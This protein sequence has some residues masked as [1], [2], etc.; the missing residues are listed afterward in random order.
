MK[1]KT[2]I[3]LSFLPSIFLLISFSSNPFAYTLSAVDPATGKAKATLEQSTAVLQNAKGKNS[4]ASV[5]NISG[6]TSSVRLKISEAVFQTKSD[7]STEKMNPGDYIALYKLSIDKKTRSFS[8][9][10]SS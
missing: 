3:A 8:T 10:G 4:T 2:L 1:Q 7:P 6:L 9:G 5:Y